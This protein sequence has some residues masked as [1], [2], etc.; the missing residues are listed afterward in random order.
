[1]DF[2]TRIPDIVEYLTE[3]EGAV[4]IK[5]V[6]LGFEI[7]KEQYDFCM[8]VAM[9]AIRRKNELRATRQVIAELKRQLDS[10]NAKIKWLEGVKQ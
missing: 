2:F 10:A 7:T 3:H 4:T 9:P 6:M 5:Q 1:M 8:L